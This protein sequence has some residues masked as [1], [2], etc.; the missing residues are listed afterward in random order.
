MLKIFFPLFV[1]SIVVSCSD[2]AMEIPA[3]NGPAISGF[4]GEL[5]WVKN[6]GGSGS[7]TGQS[8]IATND[9]GYAV[10]GYTNSTN[11]DIVGKTTNVNDYWLLKFDAEGNLQWNRTF[12]GSKDDRGQSV[13]QT[14]DGGFAIIGYAMSSD[15]DG[16]NNEG[17][18]DNW[19]LKL[20][21]E[22]TI[23]WERS[24]GFS[25]HDHSYDVVQTVDGGYFFAGFLD[26][27]SSG[28]EGSTFK[29]NSLTRH[30]VGEFW[31][32][33]ID[34]QG[35]LLWRRYFGGTNNDRAHSV[36]QANDG[37]F[38]MAGFS[39][40]GDA[41]ISLSKGSY[42]FW[43]V[44]VDETGQLV[45]ERSYGG[46]GIEVSYDIAN[47]SDNAYVITGH[48]FSTDGDVSRNRGSSD[49]WLIKIDDHG[50]L[51]W[52]KT[53]GGSGFDAAQS[54]SLAGDGGFLLAGNTKS[55]DMD[56]TE[57]AGEND[58]WIL[59]TDSEGVL[60]WQQTYGGTSLDSGFDAIEDGQ[61]RL[62][63]VGSSPSNDFPGVDNNGMADLIL[64][65]IR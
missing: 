6:F 9:G 62:L 17:F 20:S 10:L 28:G 49:V 22:G 18:H 44:K 12:G 15:G 27:V 36:V 55:S 5:D 48:T 57:N 26:V 40:S 37:G 2:D 52:E 53:Y 11:G 39:E 51:L 8:V 64:M 50:K 42:D 1:I 35:N 16:S 58:I 47:T 4:M 30:G 65:R 46:S 63:L 13:I 45:W 59:K 25:G 60:L 56:V 34:A 61:N 31:G 21:N 19:I 43:V 32:T 38:I 54:V 23:E 33:R 3:Q 14:S 41:D 24:F 7:E 29:A